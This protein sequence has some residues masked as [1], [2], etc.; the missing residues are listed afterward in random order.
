[1]RIIAH[2]S[3]WFPPE[4]TLR[5]LDLMRFQCSATRSAYQAIHTRGLT[6]NAVK[7]QVKQNYMVK[8][9]QRYI[10]DAVLLAGMVQQERAIFGGK[11]VWKQLQTGAISKTDWRTKRNS[12]LYSRGDK[13]VKGN[14]NL[15][16]VGN[17]LMVNDPAKRGKW[18]EGRLFIPS[19]WNPDLSCYDVR[20]LYRNG[21]FTVK[22]S[23]VASTPLILTN[24]ANGVLGIDI[25]PSGVGVADV[26]ADGNLLVHGFKAAPRIQFAKENKRDNDVRLLAKTVVE[27]AKAKNKPIA[28]EDLKFSASSRTK[29]SR[30]FKR[31]K[32]NFLYKKIS[33]AIECRAVKQGVEVIKVNPAF[34]LI[35]GNLKYA[36]SYSLNRHDAAALVI[37]RRAQGF[38]ERQTFTVTPDS[39]V[40]NRVNLEGRSRSLYLTLKA[41]SWLEDWFLK[42]KLSGLTAPLLAPDLQSGRGSS[43]GENPAGES[44]SITGLRTRTEDSVLTCRKSDAEFDG[45][46]PTSVNQEKCP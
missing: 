32:S 28:L 5:V 3:V 33:E 23:W 38:L 8:L 40:S 46:F 39:S 37:G 24:R 17:R 2:G 10:A 16:I 34:T 22:V 21:K 42:P 41:Y 20:L 26:S 31:I 44:P 11:R 36:D 29:G 13:A 12:Q 14:P 15:R 9:N 25:N 45:L 1:M 43:A 4:V 19:K 27:E 30:K 6:G 7:K 35:L 18:L